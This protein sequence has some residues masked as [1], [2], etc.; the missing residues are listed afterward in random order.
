MMGERVSVL[1]VKSFDDVFD[2]TF[3]ARL[4]EELDEIEEGKLPWRDAVR[5]FWGKFVIDLAKAGDE[6]VSYK[7]GIPTG[8]KCEKCGE[9]EL[10]ERISRH[11]FFLG[12]SRYPDCDFIQDMAPELTDNS[13]ESKTEYCE[14]CGKEMALKRGRF[15]A[16]LACTGYPDCKTTRRLVEGTRIAHEP[17]EPLEEKCKECG[18][19][20]IKKS[21]RFGQFIGC[22]GYPKC[23]Y[24]R[25]ITMGIKCPKC[26]EGEFVRRGSAGK[27]GRGRPRVFYGCS[28][29]PDCDFTTPHMPLAEPCPKC[30]APFIV[31]KKTKIGIVRTCIKEGCD[32]ESVVAD[33]M[34]PQPEEAAT[35]VGAKP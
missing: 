32:W 19:H 26:N 35:P 15:G 3:T 33:P 11:G 29:Y 31:E 14:N 16:F 24:T 27:G 17:D 34:P 8:K 6:M 4:E 9:G 20:L 28:R 25:P 7:A 12:C 22:S 21:G 18:N 30:G 10:L 13:G 2:V 1:L 5:E 23:K